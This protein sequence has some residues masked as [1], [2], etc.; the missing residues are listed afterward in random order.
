MSHTKLRSHHDQGQGHN[1]RSKVCH[2]Q[3][4]RLTRLHML[5]GTCMTVFVKS[6]IGWYILEAVV[7][8]AFWMPAGTEF[9]LHITAGWFCSTACIS[10]L[11]DTLAIL[12]HLTLL[13]SELASLSAIGHR[14]LAILSAVGLKSRQ[15]TSSCK[16]IH[17][18][19]KLCNVLFSA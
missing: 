10:L 14:V 11:C 15:P 1:Q 4:R 19:S 12:E 8:S 6:I 5:H 17:L 13:H 16:N 7:L 18:L 3:R 9:L 2:R